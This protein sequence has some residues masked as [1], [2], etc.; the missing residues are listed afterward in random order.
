M[1]PSSS[2]EVLFPN[3]SFDKASEILQEVSQLGEGL[4]KEIE[5]GNLPYY[6]TLYRPLILSNML[7]SQ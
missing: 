1:K 2:S 3:I 4:L 6:E 7:K 5:I